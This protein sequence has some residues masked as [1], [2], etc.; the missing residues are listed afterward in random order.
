MAIGKQAL[1]S[2]PAPQEKGRVPTNQ[3]FKNDK[4]RQTAPDR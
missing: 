3:R 4:D 1:D 2:L